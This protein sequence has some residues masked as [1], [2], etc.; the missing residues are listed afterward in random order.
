MVDFIFLRIK[1]KHNRVGE[2]GKNLLDNPFC[3]IKNV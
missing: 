2:R 1:A 3:F